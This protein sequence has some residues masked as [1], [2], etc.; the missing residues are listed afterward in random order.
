[1]PISYKS[2]VHKP[3]DYTQPVDINL[4]GKTIQWEEEQFRKGVRGVQSTIDSIAALDVAK[5]ADKQYLNAK[6][7]NLVA[8]INNIGGVDYSDPNVENQISGMGAQIYGDDNVINAIAN[9]KKLRY[10]Q[11][12]YKDLKEKKPKDWNAANEWYD[13]NKFTSWLSDGQVGTSPTGDAGSVSPYHDYEGDWQKIFDKIANS[14]NME[15]QW[16]DRGLMYQK[17]GKK[18]V[19]PDRIW[20]TAAQLLTPQQRT[21]LAIEGRYTYQGV[22]VP[23]LTK[24]YDA[25]LY[26]Q[27]AEAQGELNDY[28]TKLKGATSLKD[29][30][31]YQKLVGEKEAELT[32]MTAPVK[33]GADQM[34][35]KLY[36]DEKFRG[37]Q[38]RYSFSQ[39]TSTMQAATDKMFKLKYDFDKA[40]FSYQQQKDQIDQMIDMA[41]DG[42]MWYT[43]PLGHRTVVA[44]PNS[45]KNKK[46]TKG[47]G[48]SD[49]P[50]AN[51]PVMSGS[52]EQ[53]QVQFSEKTLDERK[54]GMIKA[55][56]QL[57]NKFVVDMGRK[58]GWTDVFINDLTDDGFLQGKHDPRAVK[59]AQDYKAGW[60][61]M[62]RG[63]TVNYDHIDPL[64]KSFISKYQEN[65]KEIEG[66]DK[67]Y[68]MVDNQIKSKYGI[69]PTTFQAY[70]QYNT[71][72]QELNRVTKN[73]AGF[74]NPNDYYAAVNK[75]QMNL[76]QVAKT[77]SGG[78]EGALGY[79]LPFSEKNMQAY[80]ANRKAERASLI[81]AGS[82][83]FNLPGLTISDDKEKNVAK[84]IS[85]NAGTMEYYDE[86]GEPIGKT[87][88]NANNI[89][90]LTVGY[91]YIN[92][93]GTM[94]RQPTMTF[95]IKTGSD[96]E[97]FQIAKVPLSPQQAPVFGFGKDI[98]DMSG[99]RFTLA[100]T[101][102]VNDINT[103]SGK[104]YELKYDVVKYHPEDQNDNSVFIRVRS[105]G[106][107]I[108]LYNQPFPSVDL[109]TQFMEGMTK[110]KSQG[111]AV[112]I[113]DQLSKQ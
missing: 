83:R 79:Q 104:N 41:R 11:S 84:M 66:V 92:A 69:T 71:A 22:G 62:T 17:D 51:L 1:M 80:F 70:Q 15:V 55:N 72:R 13:M 93:G 90:P 65:Q 102:E 95:K 74:N 82:V 94:S 36:L 53:Q 106:N 2:T 73:A 86:S 46:G 43:D 32:K 27:I 61:A 77:I 76:N 99:Y 6:L 26:D 100:A 21:Q 42:L 35:E 81:K 10:V 14:A 20:A 4:L 59:I 78:K 52:L 67:F 105:N 103:T 49:D 57:F 47:A 63:E 108:S 88:L 54:M 113:L 25:K 29:Q 9:T 37:L 39:A 89:V 87:T 75:A 96:A 28:R 56:E 5:G 98:N 30:Q 110:Q 19:S 18:Y 48:G 45:I 101:G 40:K 24:A 34:R 8:S 91:S 85:V 50:Y 58:M 64:F 111:D 7:N 38:A 68:D 16:N 3:L 109:A 112:I 12:Y 44:D 31:D 33:R 23:E 60:D 107:T 97:D